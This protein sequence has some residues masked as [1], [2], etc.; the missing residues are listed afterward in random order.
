MTIGEALRRFR[1]EFK[2]KQDDLAATLRITRQAYYFYE[3]G[4]A[5][6]PAQNI[7]TLATVY[8]VSTDYLLGL[9]DRPTNPQVTDSDAELID[10]V[11]AFHKALGNVLAKR[12][13][14]K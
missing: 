9:S 14:T 10:A 12:G 11:I 2:L 7:V 1:S 6:P 13:E 5:I 8:G 3:V 4:K